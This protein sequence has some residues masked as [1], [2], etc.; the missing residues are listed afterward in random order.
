[1]ADMQQPTTPQASKRLAGRTIGLGVTAS[2]HNRPRLYRA[3]EQLAAEAEAVIPILSPSAV[4]TTTK[5]GGGQDL[6]DR[7]TAI[8]GHAPLLDFVAVEPLGPGHTLDCMVILPCTGSTLAKFANAIT[9]SPVLMAA[10][11]T[12]RNGQQVV[13]SLS[14]NDGLGLNA[15]NLG[16]LLMARNVFFVPFG[17]DKPATK[18]TSLDADMDQVVAT[19]VEAIAGRQIQPL[20]LPPRQP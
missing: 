13:I 12:L 8:T 4:Q 15:P 9:D 6:I 5:F 10:K 18:P 7:L 16:R 19:V 2:H 20:L 14:T 11:S 17:Q 3:A 1:M